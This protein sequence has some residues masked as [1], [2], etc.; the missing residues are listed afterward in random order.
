MQHHHFSIDEGDEQAAAY[1][2]AASLNTSPLMIP[3][4]SPPLLLQ[5]FP[6][7]DE[8]IEG[9]A[10]RLDD[11]S[12]SVHEIVSE[13]GNSPGIDWEAQLSEKLTQMKEEDTLRNALGQVSLTEAQL[14]VLARSE[15]RDLN[16]SWKRI[17]QH[18]TTFKKIPNSS[19]DYI[20]GL[21][22]TYRP[23][24]E[25]KDYIRQIPKTARTLLRVPE[26]ERQKYQKRDVCG[27]RAGR[28][29]VKRAGTYMHFGVCEPL[30]IQSPGLVEKWQYLNTWRLIY[31]LFP[32]FVPN[33][34]ISAIAP[35]KGE[36]YDA[37]IFKLWHGLPKPDPKK[38]QDLAFHIHGHIDGVQWF[39]DT[40]EGSGVPILGRL[41][42]IE[43]KAAK[44]ILK[45]PNL[46]PFIIGVMQVCILFDQ[47]YIY[48]FVFL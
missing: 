44:K 1:T 26:S 2:E 23:T 27:I 25:A 36:E 30:L 31:I 20:L 7:S 41:I 3:L 43:D 33:E 19:T 5:Q 10:S 12:K 42:A 8:I 11:T 16:F 13:V 32:N 17:Y 21:M 47:N 4:L 29:R 46:E 38:N 37:D 9:H 45:I 22:H 34:M 28:G 18:Y 24:I 39:K 35:K 6:T 48:Y 14:K 15:I 40:N